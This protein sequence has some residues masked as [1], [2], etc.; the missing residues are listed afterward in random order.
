MIPAGFM[1]KD[2]W[3][4]VHGRGGLAGRFSAALWEISR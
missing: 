2:A 1:A 4:A 3:F